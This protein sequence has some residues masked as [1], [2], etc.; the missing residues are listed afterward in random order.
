MQ[1]NNS[2]AASLWL[3]YTLM[4]L[5]GIK[6]E[7]YASKSSCEETSGYETGM[8][9]QPQCDLQKQSDNQE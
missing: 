1:P 6:H 9:N 7:V 3:R 2:S 4:L 8:N 5:R